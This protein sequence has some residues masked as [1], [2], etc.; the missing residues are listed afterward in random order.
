MQCN[1]V[2][3]GPKT[4]H[5]SAMHLL[6]RSNATSE[7]A[8]QATQG[9][10]AL[11]KQT[12]CVVQLVQCCSTAQ[13]YPFLRS[14]PSTPPDLDTATVADVRSHR[15]VYRFR[16]VR[17]MKGVNEAPEDAV[18]D[19]GSVEIPAQNLKD[20]SDP[21]ADPGAVATGPGSSETEVRDVDGHAD[22]VVQPV[23]GA[24]QKSAADLE[25]QRRARAAAIAAVAHAAPGQRERVMNEAIAAADSAQPAAKPPAQPKCASFTSLQA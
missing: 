23:A 12:V 6:N 18:N 16:T 10:K 14:T 22:G 20:A 15:R 8:D 21:L 5:N 7:S 1:T 25:R 19:C 9:R 3:M 13:L 24:P 2:S 11:Y 4:D 17:Q